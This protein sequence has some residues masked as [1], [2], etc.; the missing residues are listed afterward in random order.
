MEILSQSGIAINFVITGNWGEPPF[1]IYSPSGNDRQLYAI[2]P[3]FFSVSEKPFTWTRNEMLFKF[4]EI[5]FVDCPIEFCLCLK[6]NII[7]SKI[8]KKKAAFLK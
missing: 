7:D 3:I 8:I 6:G 2:S 4:D 1:I 5:N